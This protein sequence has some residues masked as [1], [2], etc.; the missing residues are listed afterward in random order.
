MIDLRSLPVAALVSGLF[1]L[2]TLPAHAQSAPASVEEQYREGLYLRE[3]GRPYSA[4][5][6][7][8]T[9]LAGN[10]TLNRAR[11]E[12]AVAYYRTLNFAK[13]RAQAQAVLD[14]PN[15][16]DAVRLSVLSFIKQIELDEAAAFGRP[17]KLDYNLSVGAVYDSNVNA[18]PDN[19]VLPG[20]LLLAPGSTAR[21]DG[22]YALQAGVTHSWLSPTPVRSGESTGRFGWNSQLGVYYKGYGRLSEY[23]LGVLT[24]ATGPA[25]IMGKNWRGNLN[26]QADRLTLGDRKLALY[27]SFS[28]SATW[29]LNSGDEFT[30]DA[31]LAY[32]N[33]AQPGDQGRDS[34]YSSGGFSY[35]GLFN[36]NR[37]TLQAG[38]RMFDE[39]AMEDRYSNNG[40]EVFFGG[41]QNVWD[42]GDLFGRAAWRHSGYIGVEPFYGVARREDEYR[43][44]FGASQQF[45]T[46]WLDKWQGSATVTII[47]NQANLALYEYNRNLVQ[48]TLGRSY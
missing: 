48:I 15:T 17:H 28:P 42:G 19:A 24:A 20:G 35:G 2:T 12:V 45:K 18:G 14:D 41:R 7:L 13:A 8:E 25:L 4:I 6:T 44:E 34:H 46:G 26:F 31:Q 5:E 30:A 21:A 33:F 1:C 36:R 3:T 29:R 47:Q 37:L 27:T 22:G 10:P 23:N 9:I 39:E 16:P 11:L 40:Y 38:A 43:L 32:R